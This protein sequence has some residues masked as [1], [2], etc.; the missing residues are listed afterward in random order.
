MDAPYE[1]EARYGNCAACTTSWRMSRRARVRCAT[2]PVPVPVPVP[3]PMPVPVPV[4]VSLPASQFCFHPIATTC[5]DLV[6][7]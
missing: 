1:N 4:P 3:M 5:D 7:N 2:V 6:G